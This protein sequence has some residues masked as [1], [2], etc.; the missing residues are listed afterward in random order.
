MPAG[1]AGTPRTVPFH[2]VP[3][4]G[5]A[6]HPQGI[7]YQL[8]LHYS[9]PNLPSRKRVVTGFRRLQPLS[10]SFEKFSW[11]HMATTLII[12]FS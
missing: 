5:R 12:S 7:V 9:K 4:I 3:L 11:R 1:K 8:M 2:L 10:C 6:K